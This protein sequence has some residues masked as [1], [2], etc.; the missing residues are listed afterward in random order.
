MSSKTPQSKTCFLPPE[1]FVLF[2]SL[3]RIS[4]TNDRSRGDAKHNQRPRV[5]TPLNRI[6]VRLAPFYCQPVGTPST[7]NA[8]LNGLPERSFM[9]PGTWSAYERVQRV[10]KRGERV[11]PNGIER[12]LAMKRGKL[13]LITH[14]LL[15]G[16]GEICWKS[17]VEEVEAIS[18]PWRCLQQV[19][20][21]MFVLFFRGTE[22]F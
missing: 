4:Q 20:N 7:Y 12:K 22:V 2:H 6:R 1:F 15:Y 17:V 14:Y 16:L 19:M 11:F 5:K 8:L 18:F 21:K 10:L 9:Q 3:E 13:R